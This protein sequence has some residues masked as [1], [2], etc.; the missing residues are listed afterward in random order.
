[1]FLGI[2]IGTGKT[3]AAII[4]AGGEPSVVSSLPHGA[5]LAAG[6]GRY[7]QDPRALMHSVL[8]AVHALPD[9]ERRRVTAVGITGQM[10]GVMLLDDACAP[11]SPLVTWQDGRCLEE[12]WLEKLTSR[13]GPGLRAGFGCATLAWMAGHGALP[14]RARAAATVHD[15][16]AAG[17]AGLSRPV[18][19]FTDAASW[20]LFDLDRLSWQTDRAAGAG[21]AETL[22][23]DVVPCG[24]LIGRVSAGSAE[25]LGIPAGAAVAA[26]IGDNQASI[27][28]TIMDPQTELSLT[29]GTGGQVSAVLPA[30]TPR[31]AAGEGAGHE[32]RPFPGG[33]YMAVGAILCGGSGWR[34]LAGAVQSWLSEL[35]LPPLTED[36]IFALM[37]E[38]GARAAPG[39]VISPRFLGERHDPASRGTISGIGL[40]NF[41]LGSLARGLADGIAVNLRDMLPQRLRQGRTAIRGSG[42][43]LARNP[44]L[45]AAVERAFTLPLV[46]TEVREEAAVGAALIASRA[47]CASGG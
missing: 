21:I 9:E 6:P 25:K 4:D 7:E 35:G 31:E 10:H 33:L 20:G 44:L 8:R 16:V 3:A 14:P 24:R 39:L 27:L 1:V 18:T 19:D 38:H 42:N 40:D 2:D 22:L 26:A 46:M 17:L 23:P 28:S 15:W 41:S 11:V 30:G 36:R 13:I 29:L 43:A 5:E 37:N 12:G 47:V 32:Y 34:W 45:R